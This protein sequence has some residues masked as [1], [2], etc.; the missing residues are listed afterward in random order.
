MSFE[1][2]LA[3]IFLV[4][5]IVVF[6]FF[7]SAKKEYKD[8]PDRESES[9]Y[10]GVRVGLIIGIALTGLMLLLSS[11]YTVPVRNVGIVT[12]FN[13]P[14]GRTTG[15]GLKL[16]WPWQRVAD[17]DA[18]IQTSDHTG[19][20][21]CTTV[22]I[23]S[24]ATACVESRIQWQVLPQA[25]PKLYNDYK[26]D[27]N[28]LSRNLVET[29]IQNALNSVFSTYNPLSQI[30]L[31][32]GQVGFDGAALAKNVETELNSTI[33]SDIKIITVSV[34][35]VHH[36]PKTEENI[37]QFQD[38]IA[39]SRLLDQ[40][41]DNAIKEKLVSDLQRKFLTPEYLQ[42]KCIE[43]SVK[44]G[45]APGLCL[46]QSGIFTAPTTKS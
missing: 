4:I 14:S 45:F 18:S 3:L 35:L 38:V 46:M 30:N 22:R 12:S 28:N 43:E 5:T 39:Q 25:A 15:S 41:K 24:L 21:H 10:K 1:F 36:D 16:V 13:A 23:G 19:N 29:K 17:F 20:E 27:F 37:K 26:G 9:I 7:R 31:Q 8:H 11:A 34:P 6:L 33:G 32:T 42:N 2:I 44:L 40:K